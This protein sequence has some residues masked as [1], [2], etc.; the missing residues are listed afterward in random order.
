MIVIVIVVF[1]VI[2]HD[3]LNTPIAAAGNDSQERIV[4]ILARLMQGV[5]EG[6]GERD[7]NDNDND[8]DHEGRSRSRSAITYRDGIVCG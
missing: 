3:T 5:D 8:H 1:L 2:A 7:D 6:G 4:S